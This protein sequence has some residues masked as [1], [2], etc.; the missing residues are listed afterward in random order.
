[1]ENTRKSS[2]WP[3]LRDAAIHAAG[4]FPGTLKLFQAFWI[5]AGNAY[6]GRNSLIKK[7]GYDIPA[8]G[9]DSIVDSFPFAG[10][11]NACPL[12]T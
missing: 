10:K 6:S 5:A 11:R 3:E 1:L 7:E 4:R 2:S 9:M 12:S 8:L